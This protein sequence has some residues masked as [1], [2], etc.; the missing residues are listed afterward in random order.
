MLL[1]VEYIYLGVEL[2]GYRVGIYL[3][4]VNLATK[5][6]QNDSTNLQSHQQCMRICCTISLLDISR[7]G[8][9]WNNFY[10]WIHLILTIRAKMLFAY[11]H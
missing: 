9:F 6:F 11:K 3:A 7:F 2:L 1:S 10:E 5:V 4:L 8:I